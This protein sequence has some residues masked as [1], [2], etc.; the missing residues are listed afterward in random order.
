MDKIELIVKL[1]WPITFFLLFVYLLLTGY[2]KRFLSQFHPK[3]IKIGP[4]T[5]DA[6]YLSNSILDEFDKAV[7]KLDSIFPRQ[8]ATRFF[9]SSMD[10]EI[11]YYVHVFEFLYKIGI[12][13]ENVVAWNMIANYY[14]YRDSKKSKNAYEQAI[15]LDPLD[16]ISYA[17]LGMYYHLIEH[18]KNLAKNNFSKAIKIAEEKSEPCPIGHLGLAA[19][20]QKLGNHKE[21]KYYC[22]KAKCEFQT[23]V[24]TD[25]TDFWSFYGLGWCWGSGDKDVDKA[26]EFTKAAINLKPDFLIARYNLACYYAMKGNA[27]EVV[28]SLKS[29]CLSVKDFFKKVDIVDDPDFIKI[30]DDK[31]FI[32]FCK[33]FEINYHAVNYPIVN[34]L[35]CTKNEQP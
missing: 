33:D 31:Y 4:L 26:I 29:I 6:D 19:I 27:K 18:N 28:D 16:S 23:S 12:K 3:V 15:S 34:S 7:K 35:L 24:N 10:A 1:I 11:A 30:K 8:N 21:E 17:N 14:F 25:C 20:Y 5:L 22:E 9:P 2:I 13:L 32:K